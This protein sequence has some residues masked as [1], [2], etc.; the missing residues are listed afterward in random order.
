MVDYF[1]QHLWQLW[2]LLSLI[3]LILELTNGDL[4]ILCFSVGALFAV[5]A[6][7]LGVSGWIQTLVFA[8]F[9]LLCL[10]FVRPVALRW[11]HKGEDGRLSNADALVGRIGKVSETIATDG[12]GRV[13]IDGD[14]WKAT[15]VGG[16]EIKQGE[17]VRVVS[18]DSIIITVEPV[19]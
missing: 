1:M 18:I 17:R 15:S 11:L 5:F 4:Y 6:A 8:I 19:E 12:Y 13:A 7:L 9:S 2:A 10:F 3:C 16:F 14:D